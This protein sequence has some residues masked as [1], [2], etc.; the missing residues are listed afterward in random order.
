MRDIDCILGL[1]FIT[2]DGTDQQSIQVANVKGFNKDLRAVCE[3][4]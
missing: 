4:D 1:V 2:N 3:P